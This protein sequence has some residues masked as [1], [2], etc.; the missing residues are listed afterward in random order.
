MNVQGRQ[1]GGKDPLGEVVW[2]AW[3]ETE[4]PEIALYKVWDHARDFNKHCRKDNRIVTLHCGDLLLDV[5]SGK[6]R[7]LTGKARGTLTPQPEL[8][9]PKKSEPELF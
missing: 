6:L 5:K 9:L 1:A 4:E 8:L 3:A 2:S 7:S